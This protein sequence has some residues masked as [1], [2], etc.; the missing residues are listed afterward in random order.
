[1]DAAVHTPKNL[2][3][4][5]THR[6]PGFAS[7]LMHRAK[8]AL[9]WPTRYKNLLN[10]VYQTRAQTILEI[11]TFSGK[12]ACKMIETACLFHDVGDV[13]YYGF[14]LFEHLS[15]ELLKAELSKKP[16]SKEIVQATLERA[17]AS[18]NLYQG[19]THDTLPKFVQTHDPSD[20]IDFIYIDGGHSIETIESDWKYVQELMSPN[21]L[22]I[23]DDY[24]RNEEPEMDGFGCQSIID[25]LDP[26]VFETHVLKPENCFKKDWGTLNV[27]MASVR[28]K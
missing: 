2:Q 25:A 12:H 20:R 9:S 19:Y 5:H 8:C 18:I 21:T 27:S 16:P 15:D 6:Q 26:E 24:Y 17:G 7:W 14:D 23:F 1:M 4:P 10:A 28:L 13:T 22:V 11:G 3:R